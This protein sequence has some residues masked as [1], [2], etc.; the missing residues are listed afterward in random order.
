MERQGDSQTCMM[1]VDLDQF[2]PATHLLR[3]VKR[4]V[5]F[6]FVY[7]KV[8]HLYKSGWTAGGTGASREDVV[9]RVYVRNYVGASA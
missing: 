1:I 5:D 8:K 3:Q 6:T 2:V 9:D 7:D 4:K